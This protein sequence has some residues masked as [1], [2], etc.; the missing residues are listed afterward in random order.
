AIT[1]V[2]VERR[3]PVVVSDLPAALPAQGEAE[4]IIV[5]GPG[6]LKMLRI[7]APLGGGRIREVARYYRSILAVPMAVRGQ[8]HG[9]I[10]LY[11][12][13]AREVLRE[14]VGVAENFADQ[15]PLAV[16]KARLHSQTLRRSRDPEALYRAD[17][18][19]YR[20]LRLQQVLEALVDVATD[21]L[22]ADACSVLVWDDNRERLIPGATRGFRPETVTL[23]SHTPGEGIT[24]RVALSGQPI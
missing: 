21:V 1:G 22:E 16:E 2:A 17:E 23:M 20:S 8:V 19:L 14:E 6:Y 18:T 3:C 11:Y 10:T 13:R 9:A 7:G 15:N 4:P 12:Q 24:T 5:G